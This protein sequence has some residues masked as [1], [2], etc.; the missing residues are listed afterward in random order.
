MAQH[1][2]KDRYEDDGSKELLNIEENKS[3][4]LEVKF[5]EEDAMVEEIEKTSAQA[6]KKNE[7]AEAPAAAEE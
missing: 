1:A 4:K 6:G 5:D 7:E 3:A 2:R